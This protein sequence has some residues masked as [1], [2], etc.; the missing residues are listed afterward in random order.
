MKHKV[1]REKV[2]RL[3]VNLSRSVKRLQLGAYTDCKGREYGRLDKAVNDLE[4]YLIK[5]E[6]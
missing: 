2:E 6:A 1:K 3:M 4:S 5:K